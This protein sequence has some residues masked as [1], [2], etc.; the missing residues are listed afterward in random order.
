MAVYAFQVCCVYMTVCF[1]SVYVTAGSTNDSIPH[2]SVILPFSVL[3]SPSCVRVLGSMCVWPPCTCDLFL[4]SW[5]YVSFLQE[6]ICRAISR[7]PSVNALAP[8]ENF[9]GLKL[10]AFMLLLEMLVCENNG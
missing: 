6:L 9:N 7:S 4:S 5:H 8:K 3:L 1:F 10:K 2:V